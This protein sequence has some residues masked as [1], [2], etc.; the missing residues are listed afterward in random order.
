MKAL[1]VNRSATVV[2]ISRKDVLLF[3]Y[4]LFDIMPLQVF[5][6]EKTLSIYLLFLAFTFLQKRKTQVDSNWSVQNGNQE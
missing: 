4:I 3:E 5:F 6:F 1:I 2:L